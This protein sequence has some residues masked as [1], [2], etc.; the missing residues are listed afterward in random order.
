MTPKVVLITGCNRGIGKGLLELYLAKPNHTIIAAN[1]DIKHPSSKALETLPK[2]EGTSLIIVQNN[3]TVS[4][5]AADMVKHLASR[6]IDHL[7]IVIA[8]AG[9]AN[10]WCKVSEVTAEDF[11][12]HVIPNIY[13]FIWLYQATLPLLKKS[14][15]AL[16]VTIGSGAAFLT[17]SLPP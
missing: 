5:D 15:N 4:T 9:V 10:L 12:K 17:A 3:V 1:R 6:G 7:D 2:A 11:Q 14:P 16:W 8:N 13:G